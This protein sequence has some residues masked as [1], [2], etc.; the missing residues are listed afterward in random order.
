MLPEATTLTN[1]D[2]INKAKTESNLLNLSAADSGQSS[3]RSPQGEPN[4]VLQSHYLPMMQENYSEI[5]DYSNPALLSMPATT[6]ATL[7]TQQQ[8]TTILP[9]VS[10]IPNV[11]L[12]NTLPETIYGAL[13][14]LAAINSMQHNLNPNL[15]LEASTFQNNF[16][17]G[18]PENFE[19]VGYPTITNPVTFE[20]DQQA[21]LTQKKLTKKQQKELA[22]KEKQEK[23]RKLQEEKANSTPKLPE[24]DWMKIK[25]N[26]PKPGK[27]LKI[28]YFFCIFPPLYSKF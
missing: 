23:K 9:N 5:P 13:P 4:T 3:I 15:N 2:A 18:I 1:L 8:P 19:N 16:M 21:A 28:L 20:A 22:K 26:P 11:S 25:R 14:N 17:A 7:T 24:F 10:T 27:Y 6:L 12:N